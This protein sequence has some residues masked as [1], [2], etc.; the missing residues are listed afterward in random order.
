VLLEI[1]A[2][3][4]QWSP[5]E[6]RGVTFPAFRV[7]GHS[8]CRYPIDGIAMWADDVLGGI[9]ELVFPDR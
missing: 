2:R 6:K 9:H 8:G 1:A 7:V 5:R 3:Q 4:F